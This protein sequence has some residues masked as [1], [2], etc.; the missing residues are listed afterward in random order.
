MWARASRAV[1]VRVGRVTAAPCAAEAPC[2]IKARRRGACNH[3]G[4]AHRAAH[5]HEVVGVAHAVAGVD[6]GR[7]GTGPHVAY[8]V[9]RVVGAGQMAVGAVRN[10]VRRR[11]HSTFGKVGMG[12]RA[13]EC[14]GRV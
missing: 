12:G 5:S 7:Q 14:M 2:C 1:G 3:V 11:A 6:Q 4:M 10:G 8:V 9:G 13:L